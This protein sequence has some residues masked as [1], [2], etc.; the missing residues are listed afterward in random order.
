M[1]RI[2]L[3][4]GETASLEFQ[5]WDGSWAAPVTVTGPAEFFAESLRHDG[6]VYPR[7]EW[8]LVAGDMRGTAPHVQEFYSAL[9]LLIPL[10]LIA[11]FKSLTRH[12][13]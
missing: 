10:A 3:A 13:Q 6:D 4:S 12:F 2:R 7:G 11:G 1:V 9:Y 5:A 8:L